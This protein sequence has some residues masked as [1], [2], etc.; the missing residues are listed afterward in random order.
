LERLYENWARFKFQKQMQ[1]QHQKPSYPREITG[2]GFS[3]IYPS[4]QN[5]NANLPY[6]FGVPPFD[7]RFYEER[8]DVDENAYEI[9]DDLYDPRNRA[10]NQNDVYISNSN[11]NNDND[12]DAMS[13]NKILIPSPMHVNK[14][15]AVGILHRSQVKQKNAQ[16][17]QDVLQKP[18]QVEFDNT[19][20]L[21]IVAL[22]AGL[23]CAFST[24]VS[25]V[26][27]Y[28]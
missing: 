13:D 7:S 24:G 12:N 22:I 20:S 28:I 14:Q 15:P 17:Q 6:E 18:L 4:K 9:D 2:P 26:E 16:N 21:Y 23:S 11:N 19:M 1:Q 10:N 5:Q 8:S 25:K 3:F 27:V